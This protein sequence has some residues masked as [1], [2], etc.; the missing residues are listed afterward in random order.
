MNR[1]HLYSESDLELA[2]AIKV[3]AHPAR[4]SIIKILSSSNSLLTIEA[5]AG[6]N[7]APAQFN[8]HIKALKTIGVVQ[9]MPLQLYGL[10]QSAFE[11]FAGRLINLLPPV[12]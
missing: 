12:Q 1:G 9:T 11:R 4:I 5:F 7:L 8:K 3:F 2:C 10:H 6:L